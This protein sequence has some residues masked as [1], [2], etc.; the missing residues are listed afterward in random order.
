MK[1]TC[2]LLLLAAACTTNNEDDLIAD[3]ATTTTT[4]AADGASDVA[5]PSP[6]LPPAQDVL[7][8]LAPPQL[9]A[10]DYACT[11]ADDCCVIYKTCADTLVLVTGKNRDQASAAYAAMKPATV[12]PKTCWPCIPPAVEVSCSAGRCRA[13]R[14]SVSGLDQHGLTS[15]HC[16]ARLAVDGGV[17]PH[18]L[19]SELAVSVDDPPAQQTTFRCH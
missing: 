9:P 1:I 14:V 16:G 6:D 2:A 19:L 15:P 5:P 17:A 3:A 8:D 13:E 12:D 4:D 7:T 10:E 18:A 11:T